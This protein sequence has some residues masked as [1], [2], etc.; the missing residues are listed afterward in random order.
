MKLE[1]LYNR[2]NV[3]FTQLVNICTKYFGNPRIGKSGHYK[4]KTFFQDDPIINLQPRKRE[5]KMAKPYQVDQVRKI[6]ERMGVL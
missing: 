4:F 6:L 1:I 2:N 5:K 3:H